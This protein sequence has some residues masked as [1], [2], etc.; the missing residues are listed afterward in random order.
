MKDQSLRLLIQRAGSSCN[1]ER[2]W[3]ERHGHYCP[4][5]DVQRTAFLSFAARSLVAPSM[6]M[7]GDSEVTVEEKNFLSNAGIPFGGDGEDG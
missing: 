5:L 3:C 7:N 6:P 4:Q 1:S 2:G